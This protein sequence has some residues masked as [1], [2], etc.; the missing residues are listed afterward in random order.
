MCLLCRMMPSFCSVVAT[1]T[2]ACVCIAWRRAR[3]WCLSGDTLVSDKVGL[4]VMFCVHLL[5]DVI[6]LWALLCPFFWT[7]AH[8]TT[9]DGSWSG[10]SQE[11]YY[12]MLKW[13]KNWSQWPSGLR[14]VSIA[15]HFL[16]LRVRFLPGAWVSVVSV[17]CC[18]V[19]VS[20]TGRSLV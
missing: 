6:F 10:I 9:V 14:Q 17:V 13:D 11:Q 1:G 15:H 7:H 5:Y 12:N 3:Q 8:E 20:A 2:A 16:R 18:Q 19:E 4:S